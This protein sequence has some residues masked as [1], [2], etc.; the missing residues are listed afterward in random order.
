MFL[1]RLKSKSL[2]SLLIWL[3]IGLLV[4]AC[5]CKE[6]SIV[7]LHTND[8]H[9]SILPVS[10]VGGMAERATI[11]DSLKKLY[12]DKILLLDAGDFNTGQAV[13]NMFCA[14]PDILA[15]NFMK[16]DAVTLG[17]HE[18]DHPVD[19]LLQQM[20]LANFPFVISNVSYKGKAL[21]VET[22]V[23]EVNG[24]RI[25]LF[26]ILTGETTQI[27]VNVH[28]VVFADEVESARK[29]VDVLQRE[30]VDLIV[31]IVHLGFTESA[32]DYVT[33]QKL[34]AAVDG[35]DIIVDGHSHS[36]IEKP[37]RI[38][39][40]WIVT[41]NQ[42]GRFIG[43]GKV[44]MCKGD[45]VSFEWKPL[46]VKNVRPHEDL[47][48]ILQP[49]EDA[50]NKDLQTVIGEATDTFVLFQDEENLGR[51][52]EVAL[53]NL[54]ADALKW[55]AG[56][57]RLNVDFALTNAGGIRDELSEGKITKGDILSILPFG[58]ELEIVAMKGEDVV[59]LF[60]FLATVELGKG[61]FPQVSEEVRVAFNRKDKTLKSLTIG[62]APVDKNRI[63]YMATCDY[64]AAGKDGYSAGLLNV[65]NRQK[66]S[67]LMAD[68]LME[69]IRQQGKVSPKME[70][71]IKL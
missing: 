36:Y 42:S 62:G 4:A 9:G 37:L 13:S 54:V 46:P 31:G 64:V 15:Y 21:G 61:T 33:S 71:R 8:S 53:G 11:I 38:N 32:P 68:V 65:V 23:K 39:E 57:L 26:G 17:N 66:T 50:A 6:Q 48:A 56:Q 52:G 70:G 1:Y 10:G 51:Y 40:T 55:K 3:F 24:V 25:G 7:L 19:T 60:D 30:G 29:A 49:Y 63:Y 16:Y 69:Y 45:I 14:R 58:N 59:K 44:K 67:V 5:G 28:D 27:S 22:L 43:E 34:A 20:R 18:F 2:Y 35:I 41:A 47:Q 12:P